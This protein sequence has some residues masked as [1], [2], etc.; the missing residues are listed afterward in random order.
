LGLL[1]P[2]GLVSGAADG[3]CSTVGRTGLSP[4]SMFTSR[5]RPDQSAAMRDAGFCI[6]ERV[7]S[8]DECEALVR[9]LSSDISC[10]SRAG[11]R[12]LM[13]HPAVAAVAS[14]SRMLGLAK[15]A[16]GDAAV[17]FRATLFEK[18]ADS[19]WL[20]VWHQ[21]TTLPLLARFDAEGWGPWSDKF[22]I[23]YDH[24]PA[25][26]LS[27][28]VALRLHLGAS[29]SNNGPLRVVPGSHLLGALSDD[30]VYARAKSADS[31]E[32]TVGR[33]GVLAM[34]PLLIHS[35]SK[36]T[37]LE[38]RRVLHIEYADTLELAPGIRLVVA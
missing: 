32:C 36:A 8:A 4:P 5:V 26:A 18:S 14:D 37:S 11:A 13:S 7:F 12:H 29:S 17:P 6:E 19:N 15:R 28:V 34:R 33:G 3:E 10:R 2:D 22:G 24:A 21:D 30:D 20:V 31:V 9:A 1:E 16:V 35:S 38:P 27:R 23:S 25:W